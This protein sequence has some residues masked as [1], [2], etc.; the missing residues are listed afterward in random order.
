MRPSTAVL[1][2]LDDTLYLE[3][4]FFRSGFQVVAHELTVRG[5]VAR[6][7]IEDLL[8]TLHHQGRDRVLDRAAHILGFPAEWVGDLVTRF[9]SHEP[10]IALASEVP[11]VLEAMRERSVALGIV[12]DGH[13]DVQRR[14]IASLG[15][16]RFV[17]VVVVADDFGR[18]RWKPDPYPVLRCLR[19]LAVP[20]GD[21]AL[22]GDHPDRDVLGAMNAG[23]RCVRIR[24]P[25]GYF[26]T[27]PT[28]AS[29]GSC[30]EITDLTGL[31]HALRTLGL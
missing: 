5:F 6:T 8:L 7:S 10:N 3:E 11:A 12:T 4:S 15:V 23:L 22:V 18:E 14:K 26:S 19:E 2:D 16:E 30:P 29:A 20:A 28:P 24:R 25:A 31:D 1:F 9:R 17:D 21:A 13:G 27:M